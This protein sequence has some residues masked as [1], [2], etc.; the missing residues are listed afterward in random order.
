MTNINGPLIDTG[1][2]INRMEI[3]LK[4]F[5]LGNEQIHLLPHAKQMIL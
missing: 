2:R 1:Y 4:R 3:I 5:I